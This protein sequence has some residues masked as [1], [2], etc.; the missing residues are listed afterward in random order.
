MRENLNKIIS[1]GDTGY[2]KEVSTLE[3]KFQE[4]TGFGG[5]FTEASAHLLNQ[6]NLTLYRNSYNRNHLVRFVEEENTQR[7]EN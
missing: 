2:G 1:S 4:I 3:E 7:W 5:A 6:M